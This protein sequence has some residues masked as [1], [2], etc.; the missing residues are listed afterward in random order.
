MKYTIFTLGNPERQERIDGI[1]KAMVGH[2]EIFVEC[3]NGKNSEQ[4][5]TNIER[6]GLKHPK[7]MWR[8]G[9]AGLWY[10]NLNAWTYAAEHDCDLLTFEDDAILVDIFSD[11][12]NRNW[13]FKD[14]DFATFYIPYRKPEFQ[15]FGFRLGNVAQE[16]G[17]V[18]MLYTAKGSK[19]ILD[20][21]RWGGLKWPVDIWVYK[22]AI[23]GRLKGL[24]P[25]I[26]SNVIVEHD[27]DLPT[28]IHNDERISTGRD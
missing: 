8:P 6:Y 3:V 2:E 16:H 9:E 11:V 14:A 25:T 12:I 20:I 19:K 27:F 10:T 7:G 5:Q 22:M 21:L 17:N 15:R 28:N 24:G 13:D 4:L 18:C 1:R 23:D 26:T